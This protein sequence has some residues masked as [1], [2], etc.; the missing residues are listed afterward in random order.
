MQQMAYLDEC[1]F[2][3]CSAVQAVAEEVPSSYEL[4][5]QRKG[6]RRYKSPRLAELVVEHA[7]ALE[8]R[9]SALSGILQVTCSPYYFSCT[10]GWLLGL[11]LYII[12]ILHKA[13][14]TGGNGSGTSGVM[15]QNTITLPQLMHLPILNF[16]VA[17][18]V[19]GN[20]DH[21]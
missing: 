20:W 7:A 1:T 5:G 9:E 17:R 4:V 14:G 13:L 12:H 19:Y 11:F 10:S 3:D 18:D 2:Y 8:Q 21:S 16:E 15:V 6:F